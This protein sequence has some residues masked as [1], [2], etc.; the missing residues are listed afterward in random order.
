[1]SR[2]ID[3]LP[4]DATSLARKVAAL[5][6]Q[7]SE[8]RASRRL[9]SATAGLIRTAATGA[10]IE[11][12]Q[13]T[14][15]LSVYAADGETLLA[16]LGPDMVDG[17]G[18]MWTRGL[19]EPRNLSAYLAGG[20]LRFRTVE[21]NLIAEDSTL[22]YSTDGVSYADLI[23][24]SGAV[25][26]SDKRALMLLETVAGGGAPFA[27]VTGDGANT[28]NMN[29]DGVYTA[30]NLAW[31]TLNI[32][33]SAANTPTSAA[34]TGL[35]VQGS[36]FVAFVSATTSAPGTAVTGVSTNGVSAS[37]LTVWLTRTNT[38]TTGVNWLVIGL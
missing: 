6:R 3:Q 18:G 13:E 17:G 5:E 12:S 24:S 36:A 8:L 25:G 38:T 1:M 7:V 20:E 26:S 35:N 14:Q 4:A 31:G 27:Y 16:E 19:Q 9:V 15:S 2:Q 28:A 10:R 11:I 22:V 34:V 30:G 23:L 29:V 21:S 37:G 33:P 32:T